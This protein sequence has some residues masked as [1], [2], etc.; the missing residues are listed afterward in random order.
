[1]GKSRTRKYPTNSLDRKIQASYKVFSTNNVF[2]AVEY[3]CSSCYI[4]F[5]VYVRR[6]NL[7]HPQPHPRIP[8]ITRTR[9]RTR[10]REYPPPL[11]HAAQ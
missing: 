4:L 7:P 8:T 11:L 3:V 5:S 10:T 1:M 2:S 6:E 9:T